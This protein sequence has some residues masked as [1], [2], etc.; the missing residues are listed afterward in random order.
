MSAYL[1]TAI[2]VGVAASAAAAQPAAES[3]DE[4]KALAGGST[5]TV[6]DRAGRTFRG[7]IAEASAGELRL[8][9]GA[10]IRRFAAADVGAVRVRAR[11]S[12]ANG[13][14]IGALVGGGL[15]ALV[16]LDNE[17]RDDPAC[18][19]AVAAYAGVGA[20]VGLGADA[21]IRDE[22]LLYAAPRETAPLALTV[23]P[24]LGPSRTGLRIRLAF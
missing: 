4:L 12:L 24:I 14:L 8:R 15:T 13:A 9:V 5:V 2:L 18:Y 10:D 20:A 17:C 6:T 16:F 19:Q 7:T 11:D 1:L 21:L 23:A 3:L 22:L